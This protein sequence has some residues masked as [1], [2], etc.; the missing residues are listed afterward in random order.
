M[1]L[2][3]CVVIGA[4]PG[5]INAAINLKKSGLSF[6]ILEESAPGGKVNLAPEVNNF[7]GYH[8]ISGPELAMEFY[9][10]AIDLGIDIQFEEVISLTKE[11]DIFSVITSVSEYQSR[12]VIIASGTHNNLIGLEK[13]QELLGHGISYCSLCDGHFFKGQDVIVIGGGNVALK[14]AIHLSSIV[15]HLYVIHRRNEFRGDIHLVEDLRKRSNVEILTPYI[16][17]KILGEDEVSGIVIQN[18]ETKE[19]KTLQVAGIFPLVGQIPNTQFVHIDGV[20]NSGGTIPIDK[21]RETSCPN[22]FAVGDVTER[23][24]R[25]IFIAYKDGEIAAQTIASRLNK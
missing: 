19:E 8:H 13:E 1:E 7:P 23:L 22:L 6:V 21:N 2:L 3:D 5:G 16:A 20:L 12:S 10:Q 11:G 15:G 9:K 17:T 24:T 14:E 4:G 25:Q 18:V